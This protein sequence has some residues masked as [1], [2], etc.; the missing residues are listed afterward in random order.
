MLFPCLH[1]N[2]GVM[3]ARALMHM[4]LQCG[5]ANAAVVETPVTSADGS[6]AVADVFCLNNLSGHLGSSLV[7]EQEQAWAAFKMC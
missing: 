7:V 6:F 3:D 2:V 1:V 5:M 4:A